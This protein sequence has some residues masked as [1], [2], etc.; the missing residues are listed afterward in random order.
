NLAPRFS[1]SWD[2]WADGKTKLFGTW[3]KYYDRIT[4]GQISVEQQS[5]L[6]TA[7]W[8]VFGPANQAEI[9]EVSDPVT[10]Q[11]SFSQVDHDLRTP[12]IIEVSAG[13]ERELAPEWAVT[14]TYINRRYEDL[15][16][17]IDV[18]HITCP[19]FDTAFGVSPKLVCGDAGVLEVDRFGRS[20]QYRDET[21]GKLKVIALPNDAIDLYN[22]DPYFN[23]I[24]RLGNYNASRY[25]SVELS[26]RK[27][28][29]RNWQ[30]FLSYTYS[31]ARGD[32]EG[33]NS[34][35]GDDPSI[36]DKV[37]GYLDYDQR[38]VL[39][40]QGVTHLPYGLILGGTVQWASGLPYSVLTTVSPD[41]DDIGN[42]S[43]TRVVFPTGERNDQRNSGT[44]LLNARMEKSILAGKIHMTAFLSGENLLDTDELALTSVDESIQN[45]LEGTRQ[46]GRRWEIG[47]SAEF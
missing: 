29:H 37:K 7:T 31:K 27:R 3:N 28:L 8:M 6:R 38:H 15:L 14:L 33:Y 13:I 22:L 17:D 12:S 39:K 26:L 24:A 19:Q 34:I 40:W 44:W 36:S 21:T 20:V 46:F 18:N 25:S 2:P 9:G 30:M 1:V 5:S 45:G 4:L 35:I 41:E 42:T 23:K 32:A 16:Q 10:T 47:V 11:F 43:I